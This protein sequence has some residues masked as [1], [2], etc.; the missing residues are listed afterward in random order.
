NFDYYL[1]YNYESGSEIYFDT[2]YIEGYE[3]NLGKTSQINYRLKGKR[4][5]WQKSYY[6]SEIKGQSKVI[7]NETSIE[8][9]FLVNKKSFSILNGNKLKNYQVYKFAE[10]L[11]TIDGCITHFWMPEFGVMLTKSVTWGSLQKLRSTEEHK[12]EILQRLTNIIIQDVSFFNGC[13]EEKKLISLE[14]Y[15]S[16]RSNEIDTL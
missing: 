12:D 8:D 2:I 5:N 4:K 15:E 13:S 6:L 10:K 9:L 1:T 11:H 14:E 3:H 7:T 16:I